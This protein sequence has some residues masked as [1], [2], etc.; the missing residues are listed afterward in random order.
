MSLLAVK[1]LWESLAL[2]LPCSAISS[3]VERRTDI[4]IDPSPGDALSSALLAPNSAVLVT[5]LSWANLC[6]L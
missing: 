5:A 6:V 3:V 1:I 4:D 2:G